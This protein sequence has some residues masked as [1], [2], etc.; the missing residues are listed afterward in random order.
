MIENSIK[1]ITI[2]SFDGVHVAHQKL[3]SKVEAIC[4]IERGRGYLTP[5]YKRSF[6]I[7]KPIFFYSFDRIKEL[8]PVEFLEK[9]KRDFPKLQKVVVGYDFRFGK[10]KKG[11]IDTLR[12][13]FEVEV[14]DEVKVDNIAVHSR[15]IKEYIKSGDL[16]VVSKL[17]GRF[18]AIFGY[19][20][21][22]ASIG[23]KELLPTINIEV[24]DYL[25]PKEGVYAT[26]SKI[27]GKRYKS[28]TFIGKR[29]SIDNLFSIETHIL[30]RDIFV[31]ED[32]EVEIEFVKYIRE[33]L[34]F[35][36][37]KDL[38]RAILEDIKV[39]RDIL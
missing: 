1:S 25:L 4:V 2:G 3:I 13:F 10:D 11:D 22:G 18:Y 36:S 19:R 24:I 38:K 21:K 17:L 34:K 26:Y 30:D 28:V 5:G 9:L 35:N 8:L 27:G 33:N 29:V 20:I 39:A 6:Y 16:E 23:S 15:V 37:L 31:K 14:V 12:E 32:E 7:T